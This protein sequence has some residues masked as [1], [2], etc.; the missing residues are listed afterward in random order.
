MP[1][2]RSTAQSLLTGSV[3]SPK[4]GLVQDDS[5]QV[6]LKFVQ[7]VKPLLDSLTALH[8]ARIRVRNLESTDKT[9]RANLATLTTELVRSQQRETALVLDL[10]GSREQ[11]LQY[12]RKHRRGQVEVWLW[13]LGAAFWVYKKVCPSCG[14]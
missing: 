8:F 14:P 13:R 12:R 6:V 11:A 2:V 9:L 10:A 4:P 3:P 7:N 5:V 1:C